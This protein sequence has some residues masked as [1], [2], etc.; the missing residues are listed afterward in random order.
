VITWAALHIKSARSWGEAHT[1]LYQL[2][3][4]VA[5]ALVDRRRASFRAGE[6]RQG[7]APLYRVWRPGSQYKQW[8]WR[9]RRSAAKAPRRGHM[10]TA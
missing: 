10:L 3:D 4:S 8:L 6:K 9:T 5:S 7:P 1:C 2:V